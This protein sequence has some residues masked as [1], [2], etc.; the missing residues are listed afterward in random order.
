MSDSITVVLS[1]LKRNPH[2][3]GAVYQV[4]ITDTPNDLSIVGV[5]SQRLNMAI[6]HAHTEFVVSTLLVVLL[7]KMSSLSVQRTRA[8]FM[9]EKFPWCCLHD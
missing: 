5:N 1:F 9:I 4:D 7:H 8:V 2:E 6:D 3:V